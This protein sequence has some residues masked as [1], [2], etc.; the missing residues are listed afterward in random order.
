MGGASVIR[1]RKDG[2]A[3]DGQREDEKANKETW[4]N[5]EVTVCV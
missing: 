1:Q 5:E 3:A 4:V 2:L